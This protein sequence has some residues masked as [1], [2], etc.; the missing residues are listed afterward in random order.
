MKIGLIFENIINDVWYHGA[1]D[2]F[3][4]F[5]NINNRTYKEIDIPSWYFTKNIEY[6]KSYGK[7]LYTVKLTVSNVFDTS[8]SNHMNIFVNQLKEWNYSNEVISDIL[9]D[10]FVNGLPYWTNND[11]IYTAA[12]N[13]FDSIL[14]QEEL[15]KDIPAISVFD[16][17]KINILGVK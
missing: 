12:A 15:D 14:V 16:N 10:E 5:N 4:V 1:N 2:K 7:Y 6:A 17:T 11:A 9:G 13:G 8:T 3:D